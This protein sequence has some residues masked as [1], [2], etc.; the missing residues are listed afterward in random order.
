MSNGARRNRRRSDK[1]EQ[2][3]QKTVAPKFGDDV[4]FQQPLPPFTAAN[5]KQKTALSYLQTGTPFVFL[6]GSAGVGKSMLAAYHAAKLLKAKKAEKIFLIR[7]NVHMGDSVGMLKGSLDDKLLPFFA[8]TIAHLEYF[9][10][11]GYTKYCLEK[12]IIELFAVEYV[13]GMSFEDC[14]VI[15]EETQNLTQSDFETMLTRRGKNSQF[16]FTGDER[17]KD[18]QCESG[19]TATINLIAK[20]IEDAPTYLDDTD[21][22]ELEQGVGVVTFYPEDCVR[23]GVTRALVKLY[24]HL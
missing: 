8:Q 24:H 9:L 23:S 21:L 20:A 10:G 1:I 12:K 16:I 2:G 6:R 4:V 19:L 11:K 15:L 14:V 18:L 5:Q 17:Q 13:R 3:E 7:P 22:T